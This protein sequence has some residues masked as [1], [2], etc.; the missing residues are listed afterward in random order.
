MFGS[1]AFPWN[2]LTPE[3]QP[4]QARLRYFEFTAARPGR[5]LKR[6]VTCVVGMFSENQLRVNI[7][8]SAESLQP[9][10]SLRP[11]VTNASSAETGVEKCL[12][13]NLQSNHRREEQ[14]AR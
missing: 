2:L 4:C 3:E 1:R 6:G 7:P 9:L 12:S 14:D 5:A 10:M 13:P 8:E 11:V